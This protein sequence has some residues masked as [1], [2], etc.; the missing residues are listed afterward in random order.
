MTEL[1]KKTIEDVLSDSSMRLSRA[2]YSR[3]TVRDYLNQIDPPELAA[4]YL[5]L[6]EDNSFYDQVCAGAKHHHHWIGGLADHVTEMIGIAFDM[7]DLY[8]GDLENRITKS[9]IIIGCYLHDF[10]KVWTYEFIQE[11]DREKD[12]K[13]Y[14]EEQTFKLLNSG[15]FAILDEESKT[16]L[17]LGRYGIVPTDM[18]WSAVLF[19][20]GG[21]ADACWG[22]GRQTN[23]SNTVMSRNPLAVLMHIVDMYSSQILGRSI[24]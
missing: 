1:I 20:E 13:K 16:L 23:T 9:D 3:A 24:A 8:R 4:K 2:R 7:Y 21:W 19:A 10:A 11:E 5:K 14:K 17:T 12:P 15:A 6:H 22:P 18:Q